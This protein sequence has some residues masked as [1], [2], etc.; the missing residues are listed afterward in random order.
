MKQAGFFDFTERQK[1]LLAT[2]DFLDRPAGLRSLWSFG[3]A[4]LSLQ[5]SHSPPHSRPVATLNI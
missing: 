4:A 2:R 3:V 5:N 1:K